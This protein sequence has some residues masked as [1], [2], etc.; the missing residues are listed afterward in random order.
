MF[1]LNVNHSGV[2]RESLAKIR[3]WLNQKKKREREEKKVSKLI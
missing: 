2:I 1:F 3:K